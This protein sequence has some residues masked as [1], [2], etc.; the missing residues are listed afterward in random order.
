MNLSKHE[1]Q[2]DAAVHAVGICLG[3]A[4]AGF[5][6]WAAIDSPNGGQVAPVAVYVFGLLAMLGCS[7]AY[8]VW[9]SYRSRDWLRRLDHAAIFVMIAGTY[10]PL[11]LRLPG[12][13]PIVLAAGVWSAAAAGIVVKLW[14][15][16]RVE[17]ISIALY[18]A[19]GWCGLI[20]IEPLLLSFP[21]STLT[22]LLV[23]GLIYSAGVALH[24][25]RNLPYGRALWH[26][27]VLLAAAVHYAALLSIMDN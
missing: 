12:A 19:L 23:G 16:R 20:A 15:P 25:S 1:H 24:V 6:L 26:A 4:G 13:W 3:V 18:L 5:M 17:A 2:A 21:S 22:L 11:V 14:Q 8:N 10:T 7:A 9:R 27:S